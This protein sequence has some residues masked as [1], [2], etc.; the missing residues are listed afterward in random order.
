[1]GYGKPELE[2]KWWFDLEDVDGQLRVPPKS[3]GI[4]FY[5]AQKSGGSHAD[6]HAERKEDR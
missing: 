6:A 4:D 2:Y 1:M 3:I 5:E